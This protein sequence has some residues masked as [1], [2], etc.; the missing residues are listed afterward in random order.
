[1]LPDVVW[2][3]FGVRPLPNP[4]EQLGL[5]FKVNAFDAKILGHQNR[6]EVA[7]SK[8]DRNVCELELAVLGEAENQMG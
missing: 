3:L 8:C 5:F 7:K 2:Q 1:M 6:W 4:T